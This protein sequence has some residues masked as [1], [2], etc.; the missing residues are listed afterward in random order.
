[1]RNSEWWERKTFFCVPFPHYTWSRSRYELISQN[2][3]HLYIY[4]SYLVLRAVE[5]LCLLSFYPPY[6]NAKVAFCC[7]FKLWSPTRVPA[8]IVIFKVSLC[9]SNFCGISFSAQQ[10][11][12]IHTSFFKIIFFSRKQVLFCL[13]FEIDTKKISSFWFFSVYFP[14]FASIFEAGWCWSLEEIS[15]E[16]F[17][18]LLFISQSFLF[19]V[20]FPPPREHS[21]TLYTNSGSQSQSEYRKN[22]SFCP[23]RTIFNAAAAPC[24]HVPLHY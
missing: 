11:G 13:Q 8:S 4:P 5:W 19:L 1:M 3:Q 20:G 9:L 7:C 21:H 17:V 12:S 10:H 2:F 18:H 6:S 24:V 16:M 15:F 22:S 14:F 23:F